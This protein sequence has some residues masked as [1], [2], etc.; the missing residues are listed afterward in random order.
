[1]RNG[2]S[3]ID[4]DVIFPIKIIAIHKI[5]ELWKCLKKAAK[6]NLTI[7]IFNLK[8]N[9]YRKKCIFRIKNNAFSDRSKQDF[10]DETIRIKKFLFSQKI[11]RNN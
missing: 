4:F 2:C 7:F 5:T 1:M 11:R 9:F 6:K 3:L 8:I 10:F